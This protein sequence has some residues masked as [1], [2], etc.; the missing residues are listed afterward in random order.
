VSFCLSGFPPFH[1]WIRFGI[2]FS[3][4][5]ETCSGFSFYGESVSHLFFDRRLSWSFVS[6]PIVLIPPFFCLGLTNE[7]SLLL[8]FVQSPDRF[9]HKTF[10]RRHPF[11]LSSPSFPPFPHQRLQRD[12]TEATFARRRVDPPSDRSMPGLAHHDPPQ[13]SSKRSSPP[14]TRVG[15]R[16]EELPSKDMYPLVL[17]LVLPELGPQLTLPEQLK[18]SPLTSLFHLDTGGSNS[19]ST[20][21]YPTPPLM[22]RRR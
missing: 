2:I 5:P 20:L 4:L 6:I 11:S 1:F 21:L 16:T 19:V 18:E 12:H 17:C 22:R 8:C 10:G 9:F 13:T 3:K 7:L 15:M 14:L